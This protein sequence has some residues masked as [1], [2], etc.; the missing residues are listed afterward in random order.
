LEESTRRTN[1]HPGLT[2]RLTLADLLILVAAA[3]VALLVLRLQLHEDQEDNLWVLRKSLLGQQGRTV[4]RYY[5]WIGIIRTT[6]FLVAA[7]PAL[8]LMRLR[9]PRPSR[10]QVFRQPGTAACVAVTFSG[11]LSVLVN[12]VGIISASIR[13]GNPFTHCL[14]GLN[15]LG[16]PVLLVWLMLALAGFWRPAPDWIDRS[17]RALGVVLIVLY[18]LSVYVFASR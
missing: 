7:G 1:P 12:T 17:G 4:A 9:R 18:P 2:R 3:G 5:F 8:L 10:R 16:G 13:M 15:R 14:T 11:S 6:P